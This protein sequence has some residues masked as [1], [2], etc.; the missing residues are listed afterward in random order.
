MG[1]MEV[2]NINTDFLYKEG[3]YV[4]AGTCVNGESSLTGG[5]RQLPQMILSEDFLS[6]Q[7]R[8]KP[9]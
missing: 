8:L 4:E 6:R 5:I 2:D 3:T 7:G 9:N 1:G